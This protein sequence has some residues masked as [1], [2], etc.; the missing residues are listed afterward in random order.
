MA[1]LLA[2]VLLFNADFVVREAKA[3]LAQ[4]TGF[5][6]DAKGGARLTLQ[7]FG[8]RLDDV[9]V[10]APS[11]ATVMTARSLTVPLRF[12]ALLS[13]HANV[14]V[15]RLDQ[16]KF[17]LT[18]DGAGKASWALKSDEIDRALSAQTQDGDALRLEIADGSLS[19]LDQ[20]R[21]ESFAAQAVNVE[22]I[23]SQHGALDL[24][25]TASLGNRFV[26]LASRIESLV[27][28]AE[29]G[30]PASVS[31]SAP[32]LSAAF[33]GRLLARGTPEFAGTVKLTSDNLA[34]ALKWTKLG[35]P[36]IARTFS[37]DGSFETRGAALR[38]PS[39][40]VTLDE[41]SLAGAGAIDA[42]KASIDI[43]G[44]S[45]AGGMGSMRFTLSAEGGQA[46]IDVKQADLG[47]LGVQGSLTGHADIRADMNGNGTSLAELIASLTGTGK[48]ANGVG[49]IGTTG[50]FQGLA[51]SFDIK[52]GIADT[53]DM[54]MSFN[55]NPF[56]G[57]GS[58]G[59][60][61]RTLSLSLSRPKSGGKAETLEIKGPFH[62]LTRND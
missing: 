1:C 58:I 18:V 13:R 45:L 12:A 32:S 16:P 46:A 56:A 4:A 60:M 28:L 44:A 39:A 31:L 10:T 6:L 61:D 52:S 48:I 54:K 3:R 49:G 22:A 38:F 37:V 2:A 50:Q 25:G 35:L 40:A 34:D 55:G 14:S 21:N 11:G 62:A 42:G 26:K 41:L 47:K 20:A 8:A 17:T 23:A 59:L 53:R 9:V 5:E 43:S 30:S 29:D 33:S 51:A 24:S 7:P 27:R 57:G 15:A 19:Y 36:A